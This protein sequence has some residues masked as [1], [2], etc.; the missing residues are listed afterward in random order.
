MDGEKNDY[1]LI[2]IAP[3]AYRPRKGAKLLYRQPAY[4]ICRDPSMF[5]RTNAS[6]LSLAVG[7]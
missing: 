6:K 5:H 4:L 7:R 2:I 3:L 1:S